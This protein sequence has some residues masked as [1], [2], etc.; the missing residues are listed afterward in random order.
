MTL[1]IRTL[2]PGIHEGVLWHIKTKQP[3][4]KSFL[5]SSS[6]IGSGAL[7]DQ[8][9]NSLFVI[10]LGFVVWQHKLFILCAGSARC[11][12]ADGWCKVASTWIPGS[13][14]SQQIIAL[15]RDDQIDSLKPSVV[16]M[17]RLIRVLQTKWGCQD[18]M[19]ESH[20]DVLFMG[21]VGSEIG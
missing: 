8:V 12:W 2:G 3:H 1:S 14:F 9:V 10:F 6:R 13:R 15:Q 16:L 20:I 18:V 4:V 19:R 5:C 17:L 7:W 21:F 11:V